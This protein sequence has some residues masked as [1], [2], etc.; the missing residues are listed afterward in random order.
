[1]K[2]LLLLLMLACGGS[3]DGHEH[4]D[5]HR[6]HEDHEHAEHAQVVRIRPEA[7]ERVG[8]TIAEAPR[9]GLPHTVEVPAEVEL[10]P[11]R[12]AHISPIVEGR[13][14]EVH[15]AIGDRV[16]AGDVLV[17]LRSV[18]LG[19][20]RA[21]MGEARAALDEAEAHFAR[22]QQLVEE[23]IGAQRALDEA[24][25][26]L[27]AT[28]ARL[29]GLSQ[30]ASVYGGGGRGGR[31]TIRS[32]IAGEVLA[33]HAT[34]GEVAPP[35]RVLFEIADLS[36]VW[37]MGDVFAQDVGEVRPGASAALTLRSVPGERYRGTLD[38]VGPA[39]DEHTRT[40]PVR[41]V[42]ANEESE[43]ARPLRPGLFGTLHVE[44][45]ESVDPAHT[46]VPMA[47]VQPLGDQPHVFVPGESQSEYIAHPVET[48]RSVA[49]RIEIVRGLAPGDRFVAEGAFV[50]RSEA[51][52]EALGGHGHGH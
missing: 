10:D 30:R 16:E 7:V 21:A 15:A 14:E 33:R 45:G 13:I 35:G 37:V 6:E 3:V 49:D 47:A 40:L 32:P 28:R 44:T 17:V 20:T 1:M 29:R 38:Y 23:G 24:R 25:R 48:G 36:E 18:A 41:M 39:L 26:E 4:D 42:L 12:T 52:R 22:Q 5:E 9:G 50:L 8:I 46:S 31:T 19:E 2:R 11:D 43:G 27:E 51:Q 34:V